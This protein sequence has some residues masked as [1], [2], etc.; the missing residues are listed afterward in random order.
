MIHRRLFYAYA[1]CAASGAHWDTFDVSTPAGRYCSNRD[2]NWRVA[3]PCVKPLGWRYG[4]DPGPLAVSRVKTPES[5]ATL[6]ATGR[7][8][9][10][11]TTSGCG[12]SAT[13]E[14]DCEQPDR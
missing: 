1:A 3:S 5:P 13:V 11:D 14:P 8:E 10:Q 4:Y 6:S 9:G 12:R 2:R 7:F